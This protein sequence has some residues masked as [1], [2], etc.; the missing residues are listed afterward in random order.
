MGSHKSLLARL[1][2]IPAGSSRLAEVRTHQLPLEMNNPRAT[3]I[4]LEAFR[5]HA[6]KH[7]QPRVHPEVLPCSQE[8]SQSRMA[9]NLHTP[10]AVTFYVLQP[11][12]HTQQTFEE[13]YC[14]HATIDAIGFS[15]IQWHCM[16]NASMRRSTH[17]ATHGV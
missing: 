1:G 5:G 7:T 14:N 2:H 9:I 16:C 8:C 11:I 13:A 17:S 3:G 15:S 12:T 10:A 6:P 4:E